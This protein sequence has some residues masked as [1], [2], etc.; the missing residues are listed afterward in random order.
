MNR[1]TDGLC[2]PL[3]GDVPLDRIYGVLA[4]VFGLTSAICV[5][6]F[7]LWD[8]RTHWI[9]AVELSQGVVH[10][11]ETHAGWAISRVP[12]MVQYVIDHDVNAH[13]DRPV[14]WAWYREQW[15]IPLKPDET[16]PALQ[17]ATTPCC[18]VVY[19]PQAVGIALARVAGGG[20]IAMLLAGR[21]AALLVGVL[22]VM[23]AIRVA[24]GYRLLFF[25]VG[26]LPLT[27]GQMA[28]VG[29][30][31]VFMPVALLLAAELLRILVEGEPSRRSTCGVAALAIVLGMARFPYVLLPCVLLGA[32][33]LWR[34]PA[35]LAFIG[36]MLVACVV[37]GG[38]VIAAKRLVPAVHSGPSVECHPAAQL[39][40][41]L[42]H[43]RDVAATIAVK[44]REEGAWIAGTAT[45]FASAVRAYDPLLM[46]VL[47]PAWLFLLAV[48]DRPARREQFPRLANL[49]GFE[50][51]ER[52]AAGVPYR[53]TAFETG[54]YVAT[55]AVI[56]GMITFSMYLWWNAP[57]ARTLAGIQSRYF[58]P[59]GLLSGLLFGRLPLDWTGDRVLLVKT[60]VALAIAGFAHGVVCVLE[61]YWRMPARLWFEP[62]V[63]TGLAFATVWGSSWL[64]TWN[65]TAAGEEATEQEEEPIFPSLRKVA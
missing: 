19:V 41:T 1:Q 56:V 9:R 22:V 58:F 55:T 63:T 2:L 12:V 34:P 13:S 54:G 29:A 39:R 42:R 18:Y 65:R 51:G 30:D 37:T 46:S 5:P 43:P 11:R 21:I 24:P 35:R 20:P 36:A 49:Y 7:A 3:V 62:E 15:S 16:L 40:H 57:G 53:F 61:H 27:V 8:E 31:A 48:V 50:R 6:P 28:S 33:H 44:F 60:T 59:L 14:D 32:V 26:L 64:A 4:L 45:Q 38:W 10:P 25:G 52:E 47:I 17:W 23:R